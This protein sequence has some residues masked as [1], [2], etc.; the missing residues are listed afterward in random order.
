MRRGELEQQQT[1]DEAA[2]LLTATLDRLRWS[3][4]DQMG[5]TARE[6]MLDLRPHVEAALETLVDI[7][8]RRGPTDGEQDLQHAFKM[9]L[10]ARRLPG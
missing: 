6:A 5:T 10:D 1:V 7:E 3:P 2:A 4:S 8:E 9:L